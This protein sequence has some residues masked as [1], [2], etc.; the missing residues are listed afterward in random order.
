MTIGLLGS[1]GSGKTYLASMFEKKLGAKIVYE[2]EFDFPDEIFKNLQSG[3]HLFE[4]IVWFR[5]KQLADH[6]KIQE[7]AREHA[8][9]VTDST[10]YQYQ[11]Y[12]D[13][14]ISDSF[15]RGILSEMGL[16]DARSNQALDVYVYLSASRSIILDFLK[17]KDPTWP[18]YSDITFEFLSQMAEVT[19]AY[20]EQ[21]RNQLPNLIE[22]RHEEFD[23]SSERDFCRLWELIQLQ[24][25]AKSM[26]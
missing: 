15:C 17:R 18:L 16:E 10:L 25:A 9:V 22:I 12:V 21:K 14:F 20:V 2:R 1:P 7:L 19:D 11:M 23:F 8:L 13:H 4:T 24:A 6:K 5:N 26:V 3:K